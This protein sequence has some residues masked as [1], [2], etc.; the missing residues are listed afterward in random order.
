LLPALLKARQALLSMV[1]LVQLTV[2][3]HFLPQV[4]GTQSAPTNQTRV[5]FLLKTAMLSPGEVP[6]VIRV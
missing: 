1:A 6:P 3:L 2:I 5:W 4:L